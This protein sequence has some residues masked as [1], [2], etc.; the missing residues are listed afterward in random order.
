M[1]DNI[2]FTTQE[3]N[4]EIKIDKKIIESYESLNKKIDELLTKI[5]NKKN[6]KRT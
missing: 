3:L 4:Q 2:E 6:G 5:K 1:M